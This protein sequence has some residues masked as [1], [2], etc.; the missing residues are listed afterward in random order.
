MTNPCKTKSSVGIKQA[1]ADINYF[2]KNFTLL[3]DN[4][5]IGLS[6]LGLLEKYQVNGNQAHDAN[7]VATMLYH[8]IPSVVTLNTKDFVFY[9]EIDTI[10]I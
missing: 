4:K 7:I 3:D 2:C 5:F 9:K 6:L 1:L 8:K 10:S